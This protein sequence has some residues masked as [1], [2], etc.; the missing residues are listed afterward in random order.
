MDKRRIVYVL[1][2]KRDPQRHYIGLTANLRSRVAAH[3]AGESAHTAK[4]RPWRLAVS[5]EFE[6]ADQATEFE[7]YLKSGSGRA[8]AKRHFEPRE[9]GQIP[10]QAARP[11]S[12]APRGASTREFPVVLPDRV[13]PHPGQ[14]SRRNKVVP[15]RDTTRRRI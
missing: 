10:P 13:P 15:S 2:S 8:F 6:T 1:R 3:N 14:R 7:R 11:C 12:E 9:S 4:Y 5:I